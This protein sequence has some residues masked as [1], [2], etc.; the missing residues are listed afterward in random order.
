MDNQG[1]KTKQ[2]W[3]TLRFLLFLF[4]NSHCPWVF[5]GTLIFKKKHRSGKI[6]TV[7]GRWVLGGDFNL[8]YVHPEPWGK[9]FEL[10]T[11]PETNQIA[12]ENRPKPNR[13]GSYS[14]HPFLGAFAVSFREG[15]IFQMGWLKPPTWVVFSPKFGASHFFHFQDSTVTLGSTY[16]GH[17]RMQGWLVT[18]RYEIICMF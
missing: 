3:F 9:R 1:R 2:R 4:S 6:A 13:K 15:N 10:T 16:P 17:P 14:N 12:P 5:C 7:P 18:T 11:L 8:F